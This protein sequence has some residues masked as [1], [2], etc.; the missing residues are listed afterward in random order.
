MRHNFRILEGQQGFCSRLAI[1]LYWSS[2]DLPWEYV[3]FNCNSNQDTAVRM[4]WLQRSDTDV[5]CTV[6]RGGCLLLLTLH[7]SAYECR[8]IA[9]SAKRRLASTYKRTPFRAQIRVIAFAQ[10]LPEMQ[11]L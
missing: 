10:H 2:F 5:T 1:Y 3:S 9:G 6:C 11:T 7:I 4:H 8:N